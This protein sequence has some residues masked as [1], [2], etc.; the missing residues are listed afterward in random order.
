MAPACL[1]A[2]VFIGRLWRRNVC[3]LV[4]P[5]VQQPSDIHGVVYV[6]LDVEGKWQLPLAREHKAAGVRFDVNA[7]L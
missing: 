2:R 4:A 5:G 6:P 1:P 3:A 7:L